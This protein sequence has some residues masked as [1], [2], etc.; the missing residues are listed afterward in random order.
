MV[1]DPNFFMSLALD[2]A[3]K[4]Q[5]LTYP[6]P[7]VGACVVEGEN[8]LLSVE[9]HKKAGDPHA[10]VYALQTA[11]YS[12]TN[13]HAILDLRSSHEIHQYL[14]EN[15]Q[16]CF[17]NCNVYTTLEPCMHEGKTPSCATLLSALKVKKVYIGSR[18]TNTIAACGIEK[19]LDNGI[20]VQEAVL[21]QE[22]DALL[23]PFQKQLQKNFIFFKWAQ[24]L[25]ATAD[26]GVISSQESR[27]YVHQLRDRCD[28]MVIGGETVREDRPTL[29]ARLIDG[30]APDILIYSREKEFD[31]SIPL[32]HV[33]GRKVY[34]EDNLQRMQSYKQIMIEGGAKMFDLTRELVDYYLCFIAPS[35]GGKEAF[36]A[37]EAKFE[38]LNI[39]KGS[40]DIIVWM[41]RK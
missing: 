30:K 6:N 1:I 38:F 37:A 24:R 11:Y 7:A 40:Q 8:R 27:A 5:G 32:F 13:D 35:F 23:Y 31:R 14:L 33:E 21:K 9:A 2:E 28:L 10:E 25:N 22:C 34:I 4:Y 41:K 36:N 26:D 3:W 12:L 39:Q 19:L 15:H 18:D 29:D 16:G 17:E 20:E